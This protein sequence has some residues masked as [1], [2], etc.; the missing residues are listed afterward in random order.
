MCI[1]CNYK[2]GTKTSFSNH[3]Y[4]MRHYRNT[5]RMKLDTVD[6]LGPFKEELE[7]LEELEEFATDCTPV[8]NMGP[9][10]EDVEDVED[11]KDMD[12][13]EDDDL[14]WGYCLDDD[15]VCDD[16]YGLSDV[17]WYNSPF[18]TYIRNVDNTELI[19]HS[20]IWLP[21]M[22]ISCTFG[23]LVGISY[24]VTESCPM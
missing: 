15:D 2:C 4:T 8:S 5:E 13:V 17:E 19:S 7:E 21:V 22:Y 18:C 23:F 3:Q 11:V 1:A 6:T 12:D 10:V 20:L 14:R 9:L 24:R 16:L